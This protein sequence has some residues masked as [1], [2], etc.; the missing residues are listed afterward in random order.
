MWRVRHRSQ[1]RIRRE[2][3][4]SLSSVSIL[5]LIG[6]L[7]LYTISK[8]IL[9]DF[10]FSRW[11]P[12]VIREL[13]RD[14]SV[15]WTQQ[16]ARSKSVPS[17]ELHTQ[18]AVNVITLKTDASRLKLLE[19]LLQTQAVDFKPFYAIDGRVHMAFKDMQGFAGPRRRAVLRISEPTVD[20]KI[21]HERLKFACFLTHVT[22]WKS[23]VDS[24]APATI[25]LEDD[26]TLGQQFLAKIDLAI[27][28]LPSNWDIMYLGSTTPIFG[29]ELHSGVWQLRGALGTFGYVISQAG[30]MKM[31]DFAVGSDK[32]IDHVLDSA[33]S[34]GRILAFQV[35]PPLVVHRS[36]MVTTLAY[37]DA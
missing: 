19:R 35:H 1:R 7:Q 29:G 10:K 22:L 6:S 3:R 4:L 20:Y 12:R 28:K 36:D 37:H 5:S 30:A 15:S 14:F 34:T 24:F 21:L 26:V 17:F 16:L 23:F 25:I 8:H 13:Q 32:P 18:L 33:I 9:A 31:L 11:I 2:R 27:R